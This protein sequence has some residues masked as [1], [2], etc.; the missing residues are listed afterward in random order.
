MPDSIIDPFDPAALRIDQTTEALAVKRVWTT[1]PV[2]TPKKHHWFRVH[3]SEEFRLSKAATIKLEESR[4]RSPRRC[5]MWP[6]SR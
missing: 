2:G 6:S 1:I 4:R 3:P 5:P